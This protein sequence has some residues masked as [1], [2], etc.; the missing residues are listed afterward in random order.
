MIYRGNS[1]LGYLRIVY[2]NLTSQNLWVAYLTDIILSVTIFEDDNTVDDSDGDSPYLQSTIG[3]SDWFKGNFT[4]MVNTMISGE[5][6]PLNQ[7]NP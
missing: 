1:P 5:D 4:F 7:S 3:S 2:S 6:C